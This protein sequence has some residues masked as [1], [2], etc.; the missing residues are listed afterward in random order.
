MIE[1]ATILI[2]DISGFTE[3]VSN[4]ELDH[5]SHIISELLN[6]IISANY[7]GFS[8]SEIEGDAVLFYKKGDIPSKHSLVKQCID[9][10]SKFH[11][12]LKFMDR[13]VV[14]SCGACRSASSLS[15]KFI[16]HY[17]AIKEFRIADIVK[18]S[19]VDMII[20]HRLLKNNINSNEYILLSSSCLDH[21]PD[22]DETFG[23]KWNKSIEKYPAL[24][25][26][27]L[28]YADLEEIKKNIPPIPERKTYINHEGGD[29]IEIEIEAPIESVY[30]R[31][32]DLDSIPDWMVGVYKIKRDQGVERIGTKHV[33]MTPTFEID[34]ELDYAKFMG[35]SAV[36]VNNFSIKGTNLSGVG[37]DHLKKIDENKTLLTDTSML[38]VPEDLRQEMLSGVKMSLEFF[39]ALCEG[40]KFNKNEFHS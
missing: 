8:L 25:D 4:T 11:E 40:K 34:V 26:I 13:D 12:Q 10:F 21:L 9:I 16:I 17:G 23:L 32:I 37:T 18:A 30:Q 1:K 36:I 22:K 35:D 39:K 29:T 15:L 27:K 7:S 28:E 24:G 20:A 38:N 14:C 6:L 31:M 2:P 3:F 33:C 19:G 5:S